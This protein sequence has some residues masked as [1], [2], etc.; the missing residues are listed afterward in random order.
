M[1][2][3]AGIAVSQDKIM[4]PRLGILDFELRGRHPVSLL[5]QLVDQVMINVLD[6]PD[7]LVE[8]I[9]VGNLVILVVFRPDTQRLCLHPEVDVLC[10][11]DNGFVLVLLG[12]KLGYCQDAVIRRSF[13]E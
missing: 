13:R 10:Y 7:P 3:G 6:Y 8:V 12:D 11:Q 2:K 4:M 9:E 5:V 1:G